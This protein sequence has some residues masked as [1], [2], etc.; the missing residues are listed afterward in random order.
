VSWVDV[1]SFCI[2]HLNNTPCLIHDTQT[3]INSAPT[4]HT[5]RLVWSLSQHIYFQSHMM[6]SRI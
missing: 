5:K 4:R 6:T 1:S 3:K 2:I